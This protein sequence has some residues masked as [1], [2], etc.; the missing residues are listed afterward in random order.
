VQPRAATAPPPLFIVVEGIDGAGTTTQTELLVRHLATLGRKAAAT[1]EPSGG[2]VGRLLREILL[3]Q[4][5][6][7]P[8]ETMGG[9]TMALLFAADRIDHLQREIDPLLAAGTDVVSDRYLL[10][11][12]AYQAEEADRAWVAS[13]ARGVRVPDLTLLLDV[14]V[15]AAAL[16]R[17]RAARATERY[18]A[19][20]YLARV[21]ENYRRLAREQPGVVVL[22]GS[23][24]VDEVAA[25]IAR[26]L[27]ELL[28]RGAR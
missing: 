20:A 14:S 24:S 15:E 17:Q 10:S 16:R 7:S 28:A 9:T 18:D 25:A 8:G 26:R 23:G 12:L 2:P 22:D 11:S 21:V 4:H 13:L 6:P 19:D 1:R 27:D 5:R 3:G